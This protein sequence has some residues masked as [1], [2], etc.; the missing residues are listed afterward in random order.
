V[1]V[2]PGGFLWQCETYDSLSTIAKEITGTNWNG[3]RFFGLRARREPVNE[4]TA[5]PA[6]IAKTD[7]VTRPKHQ[8]GRRF[9]TQGRAGQGSRMEIAS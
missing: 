1:V 2:V 3:P 7:G 5:D 4:A 6:V 9:G 8:A